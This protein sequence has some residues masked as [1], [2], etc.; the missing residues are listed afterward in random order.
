[1][2]SA[3]SCKILILLTALF[4]AL[5]M[6]FACMNFSTVSATEETARGADYF[7]LSVSGSSAIELDGTDAVFSVKSGDVLKFKN[8]LSVSELVLNS[9]I[10][11]E[12]NKFALK[13]TANSYFV[14]GNKVVD[15]TDSTKY[16][17]VN[18]IENVFTFTKDGS[19]YKVTNSASTA[20]AEFVFSS[21]DCE[22]LTIK[23]D[24]GYLFVNDNDFSLSDA[25]RIDVD[26]YTVCSL[27]IE[28]IEVSGENSVDYKIHSV[29][30]DGK[31]QTFALTDG[32]FDS[33]ANPFVVLPTA[34]RNTAV[35]GF[36]YTVSFS[37]YSVLGKTKELYIKPS[38][39][40]GITA[41]DKTVIFEQEGWKNLSICY[42]D[43]DNEIE[44]AV[45]PVEVKATEK[46]NAVDAQKPIY[47]NSIDARQ[48]FI[49]AYTLK[50]TDKDTGT[51]VAL[52]SNQYLTLPSLEDMISDD[53]NAYS[54]L[55]LTVYYITPTTTSSSSTLRIPLS[56]AGDYMFYV[57]A[58]DQF[59]NKM[60]AE[61]DFFYDDNDG[62]LQYGVY[63]DYIFTFSVEDN[64]PI[65]VES[66][67]QGTG[68]VSVSYTATAFDI[69]SSAYSTEY[70]LYY[71]ATEIG[72]NDE[73]WVE[74]PKASSITDTEYKENGY[75]YEDIQA[76]A[77]NG[78]T[79][80]TPNKIG[81]YKIDCTVTSTDSNRMESAS[82]VINIKEQ[83]KV[84]VVDNHWL[85]N[86]VWSVVFLSVGTLCLIGI[87]VLLCI[88]P[89]EDNAD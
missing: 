15:E 57:V 21:T 46:N 67:K 55:K 43:G 83:P 77:Y 18:E 47:N 48:N 29:T 86:N 20:N 61:K 13:I 5:V 19:N 9:S 34:F 3:K 69:T 88:K 62:N 66:A 56:D 85:E 4:L 72:A 73:G 7:S 31:T 38:E 63:S 80:F 50:L 1:M 37:Q 84:V 60:D 58:E 39:I 10:P 30:H 53:V 49:D 24:N 35:V 89:K 59:G 65:K 26:S 51:F 54:D 45:I 42:K 82:A 71:S 75:T 8:K 76:I 78:S 81:Y 87:I 79:T 11:A 68:Y 25:N 41:G 2:K 16:E 36:D 52:G 12:V 6:A 40:D 74:I 44:V 27:A 23:N 33:V 17:M 70:T 32:K 22:Q 28:F 64:Y 14:N